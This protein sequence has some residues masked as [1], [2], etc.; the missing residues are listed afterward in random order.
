M[1]ACAGKSLSG[2]K[3]KHEGRPNVVTAFKC[4]ICRL[5]SLLSLHS[6]CKD[7]AEI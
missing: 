4:A 2:K 5:I 1:K 6:R 7:Y 3:K